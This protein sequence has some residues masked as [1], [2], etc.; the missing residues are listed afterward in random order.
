MKLFAVLRRI[1][2]EQI[3][4]VRPFD[5]GPTEIARLIARE[6]PSGEAEV[7]PETSSKDKSTT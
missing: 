2:K 4:R 3:P 7:P 1:P 5:G 6:E